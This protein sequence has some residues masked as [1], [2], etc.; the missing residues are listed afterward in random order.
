MMKICTK[1]KINK[2]LENYHRASKE[3]DGR[4]DKCSNCVKEYGILYRLNNKEKERNRLKQYNRK[5]GNKIY[6]RVKNEGQLR[7]R[8]AVRYAIEIGK[9]KNLTNEFILCVDCKNERAIHWDHRDY[10]FPHSVEPVC[11]SCNLKR[12]KAIPLQDIN[13]KK[14]GFRWNKCPAK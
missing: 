3:K 8:D 1:C 7:A 11:R 14:L 2:P 5:N 6:Q 12:G 10:N 13:K 4:S 9:I